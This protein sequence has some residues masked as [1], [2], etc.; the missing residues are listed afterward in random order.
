[1]A[2][3]SP[4]TANELAEKAG[5]SLQCLMLE[6]REEHAH[7]LAKFCDRWEEIGYHLKLTQSN[8]TSIKDDN[9]TTEKRRIATLQKWKEKFAHRATYQVL[10]EALIQ[11]EQAGQALELLKKIK[12]EIRPASESDAVF[13]T[14]RDFSLLNTT[15]LTSPVDYDSSGE[16]FVSGVD[17]TQSIYSLQMRFIRIQNRFLRSSA[18]TGVT[19]EQLQTCISTLPSFTTDTPQVLLKAS[20]IPTFVHNLKQYCCALDPDILE[21]LIEILG[22]VETKSIMKAYSRDLHNFQCK[23]K[24][25]DFIGNYEGPTPPEYKEVQ[26]KLGDGWQEKTL[27]DVK[28]MKSQISRRSWLMKMVSIGSVCVTFMVPQVEDLELDV[29][30]R[31][32]L[33]SLY[34]LQIFVCGICVFNCEGMK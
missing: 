19:L 24:L 15:G 10:I 23:T 27:A 34:V 31:D 5:L 1:M 6:F 7:L 32:Y 18:G 22:D 14:P 13:V 2:Y 11:N 26:I 8:I 33:Q 4:I 12:H 9:A 20:L 21:G 30:L 17:V 25:K 28:L 3:Q 16:E 29:H